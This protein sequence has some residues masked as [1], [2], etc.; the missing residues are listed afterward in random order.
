MHLILQFF[1]TVLG[2]QSITVYFYRYTFFVIRGW[3][4]GMGDGRSGVAPTPRTAGIPRSGLTLWSGLR[5]IAA[6]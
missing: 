1:C 2:M 5:N 3:R 6:L 4:S